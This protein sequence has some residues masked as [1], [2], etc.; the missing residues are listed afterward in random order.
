MFYA[1]KH[2]IQSATHE[3]AVEGVDVKFENLFHHPE[4]EI[5]ARARFNDLHF[6]QLELLVSPL[7]WKRS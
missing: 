1:L 3:Q 5:G 7:I 6:F 2:V 4:N